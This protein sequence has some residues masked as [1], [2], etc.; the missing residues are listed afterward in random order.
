MISARNA[1]TNGDCSIVTDDFLA[2]G[3]Q[4]RRYL[5]E[6]EFLEIRSWMALETMLVIPPKVLYGSK[7]FLRRRSFDGPAM[8]AEAGAPGAA[9]PAVGS[10]R[11]RSEL[12]GGGGKKGPPNTSP[13][14][15]SIR[16]WTTSPA[17][18]PP[19]NCMTAPTVSCRLSTTIT[20]NDCS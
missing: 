5:Q 11:H 13:R 8:L 1:H 19:M 4:M 3:T 17:T 16:F 6:K 7:I 10:V 12:G 9:P 18:S 20:S 15:T 2:F 14:N